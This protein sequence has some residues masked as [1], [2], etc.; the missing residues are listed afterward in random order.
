MLSSGEVAGMADV[1]VCIS[2]HWKNRNK[3]LANEKNKKIYKGEGWWGAGKRGKLKEIE[4]I[5]GSL[6]LLLFDVWNRDLEK[7]CANG[8]PL[9]NQ[10]PLQIKSQNIKRHRIKKVKT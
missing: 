4:I 2:T 10:K 7:T 3:Y 5:D 8:N 1:I 9:F 6:Q